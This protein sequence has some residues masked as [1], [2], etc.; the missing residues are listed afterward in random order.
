MCCSS[1]SFFKRLCVLLATTAGL[2]FLAAPGAS[3]QAWQRGPANPAFE[4][5]Q[6]GRIP[7]AKAGEHTLGYIPVPWQQMQFKEEPAAKG[8][9]AFPSSYD[10]R[11]LG[12]VTPVKDQGNCGSC[13]AHSTYGSAE[14]WLLKNFDQTWDLSENHLKNYHGFDTGPCDGGNDYIACA[15]L[16][17][18]DGPV[19]ESHDIYHPYDD[20]PSPGGPKQKQLK[21]LLRFH[22]SDL[23]KDA[24]MTH[25]ALSVSLYWDG[26]YYNSADATF[27]CP[28]SVDYGYGLAANH[29]V[30]LVGWNDAKVV[31]GGAQPKPPAAG[32]WIIKNSWG[33]SW[34]QSG[35]FYISYYDTNAV[36]PVGGGYGFFPM[37][38]ESS[39]GRIYQYDEFGCM[40]GAGYSNDTCWG[41]NVFTADASENLVAVAFYTMGPDTSYTI[42]IYS[43]FDGSE[44][45]GPLGSKSG[46]LANEGYHTITLDTPILLTAG[47]EFGI[48]VRLTTPG[49]VY[50]M[51][52]EGN[53]P[54]FA[55]AGQV[56][57][58]ESYFSP[59]GADW[60]D[61]YVGDPDYDSNVCIKGLV[62]GV[63]EGT[64]ATPAFYPVPGPYT[65]PVSITCSTSGAAIHYTLD[66]A[67][68]SEA[69]PLYTTPITLAETTTIKAK[70]FK[71]GMTASATV[72][73]TYS[74]Y[75]DGPMC[76][77]VDYC[78]VTWNSGGNGTWIGQ[79]LVTH[80]AVDA[81]QSPEIGESQ[82][83]WVEAQFTGPGEVSFW[84]KV[85]SEEGYDFL[86]LYVDGQ[87][88]RHIS[89]NGDWQ[90]VTVGFASG[91]HTLTWSYDKDEIVTDFQDCGWLDQIEFAPTGAIN[92]LDSVLPV[93]DHQLAFETLLQGASAIEQVTIQN[94]NLENP[95][96]IS[97]IGIQTAYSE[98]FNSGAAR[99]WV[100]CHP[101]HWS[102]ASGQYVAQ[103]N[104]D[105]FL[106]SLYIGRVWGDCSVQATL[107]RTGDEINPA[108]IAVR[109]SDNV[110][111]STLTGSAYIACIATDGFYAVLRAAG[112]MVYFLNGGWAYSEHI[113]MGT[114]PNVV[115]V[116]IEGSNISLFINDYLVWSGADA[117]ISLPGRVGLGGYTEPAWQTVHF[118]DDITVGPPVTPAKL[119]ISPRQ[120]WYNE[121]PVP[122]DSLERTPRPALPQCPIANDAL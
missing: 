86:N 107:R 1:R 59:D 67:E 76:E 12:D 45:S 68:P 78:D 77:A 11:S 56:N 18:G 37:E 35:Y 102:V 98:N 8:A 48:A 89:G 70:A 110:N 66:G 55:S 87:I 39:Y 100:P 65:G 84:W 74:V 42:N 13:W 81:G 31:T 95:L 116:S 28:D 34:G 44:F 85:S 122:A 112:G 43:S 33:T 96:V 64:I 19:L 61:G 5:W 71:T 10:L 88:R 50:P 23:I 73:G 38:P 79:N 27:Y 93:D 46:S 41:A 90:R 52:C 51:P 119:L 80:D 60:E 109:A 47:N 32:A 30:T 25:G 94:T 36:V 105:E 63:P 72:A 16:A 62:A 118:F 82:A 29:A 14:G 20:R 114:S 53:W 104:D 58:G 2:A 108:G 54:G 115:L 15:Y 99:N 6:D 121:H 26:S 22:T 57:P 9:K 75:E 21:S 120:Q 91:V 4:A 101:A 117:A 24:L 103:T 69:S 92:V 3:A 83:S 7:Q 106:Y 17:R 111:L 40:W 97:S 113:L 49:T